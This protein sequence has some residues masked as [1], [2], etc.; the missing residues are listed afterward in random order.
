[1]LSPRLK[2]A[3]GSAAKLTRGTDVV[4][5]PWYFTSDSFT[6]ITL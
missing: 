1:V 4:D 2:P 5:E 3:A 6:E